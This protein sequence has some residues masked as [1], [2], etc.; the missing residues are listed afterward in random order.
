MIYFTALFLILYRDNILEANNIANNPKK[1]F[2]SLVSIGGFALSNALQMLVF[3]QWTIRM[4]GDVQSQMSSVGQLV[5]YG[6][7]SV[8]QEVCLAYI[9]LRVALY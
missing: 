9:L 6:S 7:D 8:P 2:S 4:L 3:L 5:Y 1:A